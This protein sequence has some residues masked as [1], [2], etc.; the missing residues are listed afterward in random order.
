[1]FTSWGD[2]ATFRSYLPSEQRMGT[3]VTQRGQQMIVAVILFHYLQ[4]AAHHTYKNIIQ[5]SFH[6]INHTSFDCR[7]PACCLKWNCGVVFYCV[8]E[9][10]AE[11]RLCWGDFEH[12]LCEK[13]YW[14]SMVWLKVDGAVLSKG[15]TSEGLSHQHK[16]TIALRPWLPYGSFVMLKQGRGKQCWSWK[17]TYE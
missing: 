10:I 15:Q 16:K 4:S 13:G 6:F 8:N 2:D 17:N 5:G 7:T 12:S 9:S 11:K 14:C 1:M 3:S